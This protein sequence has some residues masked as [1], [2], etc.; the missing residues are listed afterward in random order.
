MNNRRLFYYP[1]VVYALL[2]VGVWLFSWVMEVAGLLLGDG[3]GISS[4]VSFEGVRWAVRSASTS[5]DAAPWAT[6][7]LFITSI[8]LFVG[9]GM[10]RSARAAFH[11]VSLTLV[12][13]RAWLAAAVVFAVYLLLLFMCTVYP[14]NLLLGVTGSFY[15]SPLLQGRIILCF[16]GVLPVTII[17]GFI[18]GNYR[19]VVDV[20]RSVGEA[21]SLYAPA[22]VAVIPA[23]GIVPCAERVGLLSLL[24]VTEQGAAVFSDIMYLV[25]FLYIML[26]LRRTVK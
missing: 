11:G 9:S 2:L 1:A 4:L 14:W 19:S 3:L 22:L 16:A 8:G 7:M 5:L 12:E 23:T 24:G 10:V 17:Y 13:K 21:F 25:P 18:Y 26:L 20:A 6:I 15:T